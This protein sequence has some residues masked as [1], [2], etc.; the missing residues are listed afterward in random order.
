MTK[1]VCETNRI[2]YYWLTR[3]ERD[4]TPTL[5]EEYRKWKSDGYKVCTFFSGDG[6]LVDLTKDLLLH[7]KEVI[8]RNS[9]ETLSDEERNN[10]FPCAAVSPA[11]SKYY[12][13]K[14]VPLH[15]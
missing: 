12:Q 1:E 8:S 4:N 11:I 6:N 13:K 2:V 15:L 14:N 7:N 9:S 5:Q 10:L 3:E